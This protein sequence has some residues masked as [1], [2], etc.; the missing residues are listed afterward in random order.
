[1]TTGYL[2]VFRMTEEEVA[3]GDAVAL[4]SGMI[5]I[6]NPD[7]APSGAIMATGVEG[8]LPIPLDAVSGGAINMASILITESQISDLKTYLTVDAA[9]TALAGKVDDSQ[10]LTDVPVGAVFTDNDTVYI[11]PATHAIAEVVGLQNLLDLKATQIDVDN[12]NT[13][14][15][16]DELTLDTLQEVVDYIQTNRDTLDAL[17][18]SGITG[19]QTALDG[20]IDDAQ[21]LTNVPLDALFTDTVYTHPTEHAISKITGLQTEL[22]SKSVGTH[23]HDAD[24]EPKDIAIQDH[25]VDVGNPHDI[26]KAQI[27]LG[28]ADNTSDIDKIVSTLTTA[29]LN[30]KVNTADCGTFV[31][32]EIQP[33]GVPAGDSIAGTQ[34]RVLNAVVQNSI[35]GASLVTGSI[36]LPA[37]KYHASAA[38]IV[39]AGAGANFLELYNTTD[40]GIIDSGVAVGD[41]FK[42]M[43]FTAFTLDG[44]KT[45]TLRVV[46]EVDRTDGLGE[47]LSFGTEETYAQIQIVKVG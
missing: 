16:S 22:D 18:I 34:N 6:M 26:T 30:L 5:E 31:V 19:L 4:Q 36:I 35:T 46:T 21:V 39:G 23:N 20:K 13:L 33:L 27:L 1:M 45:L 9:N 40:L 44:I 42:P 7:G 47:A 10:V 37:G 43:L 3:A 32:K 41:A 24:Y 29:Q 38:S 28:N 11:H 2:T 12:I 14:L 25:I 17:G 8:E 15:G